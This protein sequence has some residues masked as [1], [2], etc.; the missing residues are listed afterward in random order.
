MIEKTLDLSEIKEKKKRKFI[1]LSNFSGYAYIFPLAIILISFYVLPILMSFI[2]SF[3][4]YNIMKAPVFIGLKNYSKLFTDKTFLKA[5]KNT[6]L[7]MLVVVPLQTGGAVIMAVWLTRW[8]KNILA[9]FVKTVMFIPVISSMILISIV[10]RILL[11]GDTSPLNIIV[12]WFGLSPDWLGDMRIVLFTLMGISVWKNIGYF[13]VIYIA[14]LMA[15]PSSYYE[16]A[17]VDGANDFQQFF[18]IT[19]PLLKHTTVLVVF[20]G[21]IWS[22]QVFDLVYSLTGGGPGNATVT[23]VY[24]IFNLN[25]K[26]FNTGY[27]M[28]IANVLF[29]I[30]ALLAIIQKK[31]IDDDE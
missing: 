17:Q 31:F 6:F 27:A 8:K 10:W 24:H 13:M 3:T 21:V 29:F 11:N 14:G 16:A 30:N 20:L 28:A 12:G 23:M 22:F 1:K 4:K 5:L 7:F 9:R 18:K 15:I 2:L 19:M 26:Q 25:F